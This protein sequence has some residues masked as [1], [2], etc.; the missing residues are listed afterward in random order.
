MDFKITLILNYTGLSGGKMRKIK[1][2]ILVAL[3]IMI[4]FSTSFSA[5][6]V[7]FEEAISKGRGRH[8]LANESEKITRMPS[9]VTGFLNLRKEM[10]THP[11]GAS[12]LFIIAMATYVKNPNLGTKFFTLIIDRYYITKNCR[13]TATFKGYCPNRSALYH[14]RRLKRMS[15][16]PGVYISGTNVSNSYAFNLPA[17]ISFNQVTVRGKERVSM[18][19]STTSGNLARPLTLVKSSN[20]YWKAKN[21]SSLFVGVSRV[22]TKRVKDDL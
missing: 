15:Y 3:S 19:I 6:R 12:A 20:G 9:T 4:A 5:K 13:N 1:L 11:K 18:Y 10:G 17:E 21:F 7:S 2:S 14:I 16:L 22:P 8:L